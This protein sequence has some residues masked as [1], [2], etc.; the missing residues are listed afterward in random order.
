MRNM[1]T[2]TAA[3]LMKYEA[4][5]ARRRLDMIQPNMAAKTAAYFVRSADEFMKKAL[6]YADQAS[7]QA[8]G[9]LALF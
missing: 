6:S 3:D 5:Q 7:R 2:V 4:E 9:E 1:G 8:A